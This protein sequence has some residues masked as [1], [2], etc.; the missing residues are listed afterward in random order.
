M[1]YYSATKIN[2]TQTFYQLVQ[3]LAQ[4]TLYIRVAGFDIQLL[5][6]VQKFFNTDP[7]N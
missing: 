5:F 1:D 4:A 2:K 6:L 3:M 7:G